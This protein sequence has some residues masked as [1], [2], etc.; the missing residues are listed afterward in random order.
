MTVVTVLCL[1]YMTLL[2]C[3]L[4]GAYFVGADDGRLKIRSRS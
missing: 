4:I 3:A 2:L 1:V